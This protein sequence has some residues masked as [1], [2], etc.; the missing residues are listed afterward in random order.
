MHR[1]HFQRDVQPDILA[2][3][4]SPRRPLHY[5]LQAERVNDNETAGVID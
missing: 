3:G 5:Q 2:H 1:R 4:G